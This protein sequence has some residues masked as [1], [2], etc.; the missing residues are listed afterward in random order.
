MILLEFIIQKKLRNYI[1]TDLTVMLLMIY[2]GF[3][4]NELKT[5]LE[6]VLFYVH[7]EWT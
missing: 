5:F 1:I 3:I 6:I 7:L 2:F 4:V